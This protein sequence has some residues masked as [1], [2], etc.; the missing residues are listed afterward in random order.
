[1]P[2]TLRK[3]TLHSNEQ[4]RKTKQEPD[5]NSIKFTFTSSNI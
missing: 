1:M 3:T 2:K 4:K 5:K